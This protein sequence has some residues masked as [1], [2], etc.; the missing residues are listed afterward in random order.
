MIYIHKNDK[1]LIINEQVLNFYY[2]FFWSFEAD[3]KLK[4]CY[5]LLFIS[6]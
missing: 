5:T 1:S 4:T 2:V 3:T 6:N